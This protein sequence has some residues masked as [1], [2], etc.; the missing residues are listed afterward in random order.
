MKWHEWV[1]NYFLKGKTIGIY[2]LFAMSVA[3][4]IILT[5]YRFNLDTFIP[6]TIMT[7]LIYAVFTDLT[8]H[9]WWDNYITNI[10]NKEFMHLIYKGRT[11]DIYGMI[12]Y[13]IGSLYLL[14]YI[15]KMVVALLILADLVV[16]GYQFKTKFYH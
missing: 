14:W 4:F 10:T 2:I 13:L 6:L 9:L 12:V 3:S 1:S 11:H 8:S 7:V 5:I 15:N 16:L